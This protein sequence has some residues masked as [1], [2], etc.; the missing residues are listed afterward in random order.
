MKFEVINDRGMTVMS[1]TAFSCIPEES[2]ISSMLKAGYKFKIDG[3]S[4]N[5]RKIQEIRSI[6]N[7]M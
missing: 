3:K 6:N 5:K 1:C 2:E 4:V 7:E